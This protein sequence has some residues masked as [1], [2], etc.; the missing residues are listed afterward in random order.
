MGGNQT[1][2]KGLQQLP[3]PYA[4]ERYH[5]GHLDLERYLDSRATLRGNF[6]LIVQSTINI[7]KCAH[8]SNSYPRSSVMSIDY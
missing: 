6:V 2:R 5:T 3:F 7:N 1:S 4:L 8:A